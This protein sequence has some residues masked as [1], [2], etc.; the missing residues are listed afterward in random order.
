MAKLAI[1][2]ARDSE[3]ILFAVIIAGRKHAMKLHIG[4]DDKAAA[5][6]TLMLPNE[7]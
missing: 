3:Q 5:V 1:H 2:S 4:P 7:D 6:L